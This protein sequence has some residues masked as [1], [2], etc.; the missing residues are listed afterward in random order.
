MYRASA[1][2]TN[3]FVTATLRFGG[4]LFVFVKFTLCLL[5]TDSRLECIEVIMILD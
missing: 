1:V 5:C 4:F 3:V 2:V